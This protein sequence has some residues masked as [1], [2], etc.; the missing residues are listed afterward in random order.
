[1]VRLR[2]PQVT[3][4]SVIGI[5]LGGTKIV[6]ARFRCDDWREEAPERIPTNVGC[7]IETVLTDLSTLIRKLQ[8]SDTH[9][10]GI[11]VPGLVG[12]DGTIAVLPHI[13]GAEGRKFG[14][15]LMQMTGLRC[16][17]ENDANCFTLAEAL[18]GSGRGASVVIGVTI[19]TGVGGGIV[20]DGKLLRG[21]HGFAAEFGHMLLRPGKPDFTYGKEDRRGDMEQAISGHAIAARFGKDLLSRSSNDPNLRTFLRELAWMCVSLTHTL[22]P[23]VIVFGGGVG[24]A[25]GPHLSH[26]E[27]EL[28]M[29]VMPRTPLPNLATAKLKNSEVLGAAL[30]A[31][32][33]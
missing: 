25:L 1:M 8:M 4:R 16:T 32:A 28:T 23:S 5:D 20:I 11:G 7:G 14:E 3:S 31:V 15:E 17:I 26:L 21:A 33:H 2:S 6:A 22:D 30:T 19:G 18:L 10:V 13:P 24:R 27:K 29:W 9:S 12:N